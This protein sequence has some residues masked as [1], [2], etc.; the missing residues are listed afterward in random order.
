[1]S[2][3]HQCQHTRRIGEHFSQSGKKLRLMPEVGAEL[4]VAIV[5]PYDFSVPGGVQSH[6]MD[7]VPALQSRGVHVHVLAP[8]HGPRCHWY[9]TGMWPT[10]LTN[11]GPAQRIHINGSAAPV[12]IARGQRA[13]VRAWLDRT[14]GLMWFTCTNHSSQP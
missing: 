5:C 14:S 13:Q 4:R 8:G 12:R 7:M 11:A 6:V 2:S 1:M 9:A 3:Q 10:W